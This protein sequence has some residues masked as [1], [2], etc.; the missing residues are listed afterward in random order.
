MKNKLSLLVFLL[1]L[2]L[3]S[4]SQENDS[5]PN[6]EPHFTAFWNYHYDFTENT[7]QVSAFEIAR[8]YLGYKYTFN[9][10]FLSPVELFTEAQSKLIVPAFNP[11]KSA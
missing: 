6:G 3:L 10:A 5:S 11:V 2:P 9:D 8:V 4:I 1:T 7:T